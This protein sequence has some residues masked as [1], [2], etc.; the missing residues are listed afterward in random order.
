MKNTGNGILGR[1]S[2]VFEDLEAKERR[3]MLRNASLLMKVGVWE[4]EVRRKVKQRPAHNKEFVLYPAAG[5]ATNLKQESN[6][7]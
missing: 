4:G 7:G 6:R 2:I 5:E 1:G 3:A